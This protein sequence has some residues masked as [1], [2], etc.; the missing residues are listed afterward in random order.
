MF[1]TDLVLLGTPA[2][3]TVFLELMEHL[4]GINLYPGCGGD[5][6]PSLIA[7]A[8]PG[9]TFDPSAP[10][11]RGNALWAADYSLQSSDYLTAIAGD[12]FR[13]PEAYSGLW[14]G[15]EASI[16]V[17]PQSVHE[18]TIVRP[19]PEY[20]ASLT[21]AVRI[22]D[23]VVR[24]ASEPDRRHPVLFSPVDADTLFRMVGHLGIDVLSVLLIKQGGFSAPFGGRRQLYERVPRLAESCLK[25]PPQF[26]I[27]DAQFDRPVH[28]EWA[29]LRI[30]G[31][32]WEEVRV[33]AVGGAAT[34]R[35]GR[36][37]G[38]IDPRLTAGEQAY[39]VVAPA[40]PPRRRG[41]PA[42]LEHLLESLPCLD[43]AEGVRPWHA[44][45][46]AR[47]GSLPDRTPQQQAAARFLFMGAGRPAPVL[48]RF[49]ATRDF[50]ALDEVHRRAVEAWFV[51]KSL[52]M[53]DQLE[54]LGAG[55]FGM[56]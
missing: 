19:Q 26:Y 53:I 12:D 23:V 41:A 39:Q 49:V 14:H 29:D 3:K 47:W 34:Q 9:C 56:V 30:P 4:D 15:R 44:M 50:L 55:P 13:V 28:P 6:A 25:R 42:G 18:L 38:W 7:D 40:R 33:K 16:R 48:G 54:T 22:A 45:K 32:G 51:G 27:A 10:E 2:A 20:I 36:P 24:T 37:L 5:Y 1:N 17:D 46:L 21:V 43:E 52:E 11:K 35:R 31:W 8:L